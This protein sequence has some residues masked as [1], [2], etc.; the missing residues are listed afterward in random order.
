[1]QKIIPVL[2]IACSSIPL[3]AAAFT[4]N[5]TSPIQENRL[6]AKYFS[7]AF[8][9][10]GE[11]VRPALNWAHPPIGTQS[12]AITFYD[13]DAPTGSG[14]W[15]WV[16]TDVPANVIS[17][18]ENILPPKAIVHKNDAGDT[19]WLGPCPPPG[20]TH[21]YEFSVHALD[22]SVLP[23]PENAGAAL[24]GYIIYQHTLARAVTTLSVTR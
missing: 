11:N 1:M 10:H 6:P 15:Q 17:I 4:V 3:H 14:F 9:C 16:V 2:L 12:Y 21:R 24:A 19:T 20:T 23:I 22:I 7:N 5:I 13:K 18:K 8:G